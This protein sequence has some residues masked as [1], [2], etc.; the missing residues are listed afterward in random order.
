M[1]TG[2]WAALVIGLAALG[3]LCGASRANA[4]QYNQSS[5]SYTGYQ[6]NRYFY[7]PYTY[8]PHNYW[9]AMTPRWPE[10]M[11]GMT[12][13]MPM[14]AVLRIPQITLLMCSRPTLGALCPPPSNALG[15]RPPGHAWSRR[16]R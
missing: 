11:A 12:R 8:F 5:P 6:L 7:Y 13:L 16:R 15:P 10:R 14:F 2:M 1:R 9:P 4:Q 3:Q